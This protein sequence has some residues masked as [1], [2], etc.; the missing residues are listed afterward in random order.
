MISTFPSSYPLVFLS[1]EGF[2]PL[3]I[4]RNMAF[5]VGA[6]R[7]FIC[8][9]LGRGQEKAAE[10]ATISAL[11][12]GTWVCLRDIHL[13]DTN[14]LQTYLTNFVGDLRQ[15]RNQKFR[16]WL[17]SEE[18]D[19]IP[20]LILQR[21]MLMAFEAPSGI[22]LNIIRCY[23]SVTNLEYLE[24]KLNNPFEGT[25]HKLMFMLSVFHSTLRETST[26]GFS[27]SQAY[28][29]SDSDFLI[30][31]EQLREVVYLDEISESFW[32]KLSFLIG[33]CI[34]CSRISNKV[35]RDSLLAIFTKYFNNSVLNV[36]YK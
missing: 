10:K 15:E 35:D 26:L 8:I 30:A 20:T 24:N 27:W 5:K 29:F 13:A 14:W 21:S 19:K 33:E 7:E 1:R 28:E 25:W 18:T 17:I 23:K 32:K 34:Y 6:L 9:S 11:E 16:L 31:L 4:I 36:G 22:K 3:P 12:K 2:D